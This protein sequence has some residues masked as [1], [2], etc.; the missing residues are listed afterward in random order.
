MEKALYQATG[1]RKSSVA[2]VRLVPGTGKFKG[3]TAETAYEKHF[4]VKYFDCGVDGNPR[5]GQTFGKGDFRTAK[6]QNIEQVTI[7]GETYQ[8]ID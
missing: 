2:R 3:Q 7:S 4:N 8:L 1:R 6:I 5:V